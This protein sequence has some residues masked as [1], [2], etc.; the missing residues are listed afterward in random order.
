MAWS[1]GSLSHCWLN[2]WGSVPAT[3]PAR[4]TIGLRTRRLDRPS[5][6]RH[7][8]VGTG[9]HSVVA[10]KLARLTR[11]SALAAPSGTGDAWEVEVGMGGTGDVEGARS[12][13][14]P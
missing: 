8:F 1:C 11:C 5:P 6:P 2:L 3:K 14:A 7:A 4:P 9:L 13:R 12:P 10:E